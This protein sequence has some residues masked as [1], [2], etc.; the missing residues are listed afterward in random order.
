[1]KSKVLLITLVLLSL[2]A[3]SFTAMAASKP[4]SITLSGTPMSGKVPSTVMAASK[5]S[6]ITFSGTPTSGTAPLTVSF[7]AHSSGGI[8]TAWAVNYGEGATVSAA[9]YSNSVT[10]SYTYTQPGT[11]TVAFGA[12]NGAGSVGAAKSNYI[13]V[14]A[15]AKPSSIT[16]SG[17]PT[18]GKAPLTVSFTAHSSG[19]IPTAWAVIFG[20]GTS[21]SNAIN[22]NSVTCRHT[23][24]HKGTYSVAFGAA[25][26]AGN[27]GA[28]KSNYITVK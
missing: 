16:F 21:T 2:I 15:L 4:S 28:A 27:V 20:D 24:T 10:C 5:P 18:S 22:S 17:T 7:T 23:Y 13:T 3:S 1:M 12:A 25:N 26:D 11:Y 14:K 19:G 8:P 9:I 6:S